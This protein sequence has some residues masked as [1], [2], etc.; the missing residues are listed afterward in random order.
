MYVSRD[1][2]FDL[3]VMRYDTSFDAFHQFLVAHPHIGIHIRPIHLVET[4][5]HWHL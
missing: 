3:V 1:Y 4:S 5:E 2:F